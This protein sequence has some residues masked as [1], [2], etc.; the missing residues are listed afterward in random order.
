M[1]RCAFA[2]D[3]RPRMELDPQDARRYR[4]GADICIPGESKLVPFRARG[5]TYRRLKK[6]AGP[7]RPTSRYHLNYRFIQKEQE[8][9][10]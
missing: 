5:I 9:G 7:G 1:A 2:V 6:Y 4:G 8:S 3:E 10:S